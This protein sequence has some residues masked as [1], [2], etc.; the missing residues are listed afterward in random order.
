[1]NVTYLKCM[2]ALPLTFA[3][4]GRSKT[5]NLRRISLCFKTED[6]ETHQSINQK[7]RRDMSKT[8]RGE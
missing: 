5:A 6:T 3:K 7:L 8:W 1:M 2:P 4:F